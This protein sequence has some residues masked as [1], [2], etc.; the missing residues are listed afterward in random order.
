MCITYSGSFNSYFLV[1]RRD[2][3]AEAMLSASKFLEDGK[4][5]LR[6]A[7]LKEQNSDFKACMTIALDAIEKGLDDDD[8]GR[9]LLLAGR[10]ATELNDLKAARRYF[11]QALTLAD[12][13]GN[14]RSWLEYINAME[15]YPQS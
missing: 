12:S 6:A 2:K 10:S 11:Q 5:I 1:Y 3:A 14:A 8:K 7:Q 4:L 9:A 13:A 15:E